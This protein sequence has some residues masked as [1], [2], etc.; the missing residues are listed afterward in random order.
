MVFETSNKS[1]H[2][3]P[4]IPPVGSL[5]TATFGC[6]TTAHPT[7]DPWETIPPR[8]Q[9]AS[10]PTRIRARPRMAHPRDPRRKPVENAGLVPYGDWVVR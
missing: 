2:T 1:R 3:R 10:L 8:T 4:S 7:K 5:P 6:I 9:H